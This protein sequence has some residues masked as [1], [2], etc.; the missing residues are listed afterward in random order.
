MVRQIIAI[1]LLV[2]LAFQCFVKLGVV[3]WF[4]CNRTY[5]AQNLC[6][7]RDKPQMKC[8]GKCYL[9]KQLNKV[10]DDQGNR[11]GSLPMKWDKSGLPIFLVPSAFVLDDFIL[12]TD[13]THNS[14]YSLSLFSRPHPSVFHPP[15]MC[16]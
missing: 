16:A 2:S 13:L 15:I 10:N 7:N 6:E 5:I 12:G 11:P 9:K 1:L 8:C 14:N 3:V 4:N